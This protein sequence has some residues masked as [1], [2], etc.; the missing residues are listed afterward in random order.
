MPCYEIEFPAGGYGRAVGYVCARGERRRRCVG[1]R[2]FVADRLCDIPVPGRL[3]SGERKTCSH[4]ICVGCSVRIGDDD[5]CTA[6]PVPD[7][8]LAAAG[9]RR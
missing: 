2:R 7:E 3:K 9:A 1:C 8:V 5:V 4:P 6:H